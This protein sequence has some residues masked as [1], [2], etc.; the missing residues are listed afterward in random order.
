MGKLGYARSYEDEPGN[1]PGDWDAIIEPQRGECVN[2]RTYQRK[3]Q[4]KAL[5]TPGYIKEP[6]HGRPESGQVFLRNMNLQTCNGQ[7]KQW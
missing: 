3:D 2:S 1:K 7:Y 6:A 4:Q 5:F